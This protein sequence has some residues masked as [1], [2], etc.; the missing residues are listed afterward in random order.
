[1]AK[2]AALY[3]LKESLHEEVQG[4]LA[5]T[6][7][8][9]GATDGPI[10]LSEVPEEQVAQ[11][12]DHLEKELGFTLTGPVREL[13]GTR[14]VN[15]LSK[16]LGVI[17]RDQTSKDVVVYLLPRNSEV[18]MEQTSDFGTDA[19]N[20]AAVDIRVMSGERDSL[21][22]LDC[23]EVG[24]ATLNL[25][26]R[27]PARSPIRVKFAINQDGRLN[28]SALDLTAGSSIDVEFQT[29][30]VMNAEQVEERS[31]AL[32]LLTVS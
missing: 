31:T 18:P 29:E 25:P 27:L 3:G 24:L 23:Q 21:D 9:D 14:I 7:S 15:V 13:V 28:V 11:A 16:S 26:E 4:I 17:A 19:D 6:V 1:V 22:P 12:L 32:R 20:Q 10:D 5:G 2:G 30:A 8:G